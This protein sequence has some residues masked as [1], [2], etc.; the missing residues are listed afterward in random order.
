MP[1]TVTFSP[2]L[3]TLCEPETGISFKLGKRVF[4]VT[5]ASLLYNG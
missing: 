4:K 1:S 3:N 5:V 2:F